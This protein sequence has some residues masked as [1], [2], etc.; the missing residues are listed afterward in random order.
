MLVL[1]DGVYQSQKID[2]FWNTC[3]KNQLYNT[4]RK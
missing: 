1:N 2:N 4:V 3:N